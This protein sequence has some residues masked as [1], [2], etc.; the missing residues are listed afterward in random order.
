MQKTE[1]GIMIGIGLIFLEAGTNPLFQPLGAADHP[2]SSYWTWLISVTAI[3]T[4]FALFATA[5][6]KFRL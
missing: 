6:G 1:R 5:A 2:Y 3:F 4:A